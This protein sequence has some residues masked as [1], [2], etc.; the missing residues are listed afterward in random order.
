MSFSNP[1]TG[2]QGALIRPAIKSPNFVHNVSGWTINRD[3]SAEFN[4]G[5]FRGTVTAATFLGTDFRI[6]TNGAF[7]YSGAPAAGNLIASIASV[8]GTDP[9][10]NAYP[11]GFNSQVSPANGS[12]FANVANGS[13]IMGQIAAGVQDR[14][15]GAQ[16]F[17]TPGDGQLVVRAPVTPA[18]P[19]P[20][21]LA[22]HP[23]AD[24]QS[25]GSATAPFALF[26]DTQSDSACDVQLSGSLIQ[27]DLGG[28]PETSHIPGAAAGWT[29]GTLRYKKDGLGNVVYTGSATYTGANV[30][31]AGIST[32]TAAAAAAY[33]P[34][35]AT[36]WATAHLTSGGVQKNVAATCRVQTDGTLAIQFGDGVA[37][38]AHDVNGLATGDVFHITARAPLGN[39]P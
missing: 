20:A 27:T 23:G 33:R 10:G 19:D 11:A 21:N 37:A 5:T 25:T 28:V 34:V 26:T 29:I 14:A 39:L 9:F 32:V 8:A 24:G 18:L 17:V 4:N 13:I 16:V 2:G 15:N 31:A 36:F 3:G 12:L 30:A 35:T 1:V 7:F 38:S 6:D 22:L